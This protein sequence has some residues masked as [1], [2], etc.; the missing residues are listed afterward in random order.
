VF[1]GSFPVLDVHEGERVCVT[2]PVSEFF[3][4]S[5]ITATAAGSLVLPAAAADL[6]APATLVLPVVGDLNDY[7]EQ[8]EGMRVAFAEP[9]YVS[10]YFEVAGLER[11]AHTCR[12]LP[13]Q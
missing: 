3:G 4:M 13:C 12:R 8:Y 11:H 1:S 5:Q 9:L 10:E 7:H 2:G 6:P